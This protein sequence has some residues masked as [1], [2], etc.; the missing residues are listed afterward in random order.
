MTDND[1]KS[2][3]QTVIENYFATYSVSGTTFRS[4]VVS[5]EKLDG[6]RYEAVF[7]ELCL[8]DDFEEG[9]KIIFLCHSNYKYFL[10]EGVLN[11]ISK[12]IVDLP[13]NEEGFWVDIDYGAVREE[14]L[15]WDSDEL[16]DEEVSRAL[17]HL[18]LSD[19]FIKDDPDL[20][21]GLIEFLNENEVELVS[22]KERLNHFWGITK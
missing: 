4:D 8:F 10:P 19:Y 17:D 2:K 9:E 22:I 5:F 21:E 3:I 15:P 13:P 18:H 7:D 11:V 6:S 16:S 20:A 12:I 14:L 1:I